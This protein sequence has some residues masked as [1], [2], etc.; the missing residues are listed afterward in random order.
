ME[1]PPTVWADLLRIVLCSA[2]YPEWG[3]LTGESLFLAIDGGEVT[4]LSKSSWSGF[5]TGD[6]VDVSFFWRRWQLFLTTSKNGLDH[7]LTPTNWASGQILTS[8]SKFCCLWCRQKP[9]W[10]PLDVDSNFSWGRQIKRFSHWVMSTSTSSLW[11]ALLMSMSKFNLRPNCWVSRN[12]P[13]HSLTLSRRHQEK[14]MSTSKKLPLSPMWKPLNGLDGV[15]FLYAH[16]LRVFTLVTQRQKIDTPIKNLWS[17]WTYNL[18][19]SIGRHV[20]FDACA[21]KILTLPHQCENLYW[22]TGYIFTLTS[23]FCCLWRRQKPVWKQLAGFSHWVTRG[24]FLSWR[25]KC[26]HWV[27]C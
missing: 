23:K 12:G 22:A 6:D 18:T 1:V 2:P 25:Q 27:Q 14:L 7:F 10:K 16:Q 15:F 3:I 20:D 17:V 21:S 4:P 8:M 26:H 13:D 19:L 9:M 24:Y 11:T 5:H